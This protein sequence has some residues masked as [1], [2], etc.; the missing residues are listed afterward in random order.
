[1]RQ[2]AVA[3]E[4]VPC[5]AASLK[6]QSAQEQCHIPNV[7][8][9]VAVEGLMANNPRQAERETNEAGQTSTR[10]AAEQTAQ[11]TRSMADATE[12]TARTGAE[13]VRRN[14]EN[15]SNN[16]RSGEPDGRTIDGS[17]G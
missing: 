12:R 4:A 10:R 17:V 6:K 7:H 9:E 2:I 15:L 13:A 8:L 16:W 1:M 14:A 11:T 3:A 5:S